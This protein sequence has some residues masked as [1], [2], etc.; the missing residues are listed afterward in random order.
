MTLLQL[1]KFGKG[2]AARE[3]ISSIA[4]GF[5]ALF[6]LLHLPFQ[7]FRRVIGTVVCGSGQKGIPHPQA[8]ME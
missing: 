8:L 4:K 6:V 1:K 2:K 5:L 3:F 7:F